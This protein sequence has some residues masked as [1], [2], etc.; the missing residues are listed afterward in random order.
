MLPSALIL[1][2]GLAGDAVLGE[3]GPLFQRAPH[4]IVLAGRAVAWFD[5]KLNRASREPND[6]RIRGIVTVAILLGL[7]GGLGYGVHRLAQSVA[8]GW[9]FE[10]FVVAI[11]LAQRSLF[12]H[13]AD[14][15]TA[16][17][18]GGV[19]GGRLMVARIVG[20]DV[21]QLDRH[22]IARAAIESLAENFADAVVAPVFWYCAAGLPGLLAYKMLN[23]LDSMIGYRSPKYLYF[24]WA[25]ARADDLA[26]FIPARLSGLILALA[27]TFAPGGNPKKDLITLKAD[28]GNHPSPNSG[29]PEAAMA[30]GLGLALGGP[31]RYQGGIVEG[32]WIGNGRAMAETADIHRALAAFVAACLIN[33]GLAVEALRIL[34]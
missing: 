20:R 32:Q 7:A 15:A 14:V 6:L 34:G 3:M 12:V 27:M 1:P 13:V 23:T 26:N 25:A 18:S 24:G 33:A 8:L 10:A 9:V 31:R 30:G 29:S 17:K 21:A 5:A 4:P 22:G 16:L 28:S 19:D 2:A 11:F